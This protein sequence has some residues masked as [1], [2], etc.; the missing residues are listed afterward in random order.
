[1]EAITLGEISK[2]LAW[3]V[4][5]IGSITAIIVALKKIIEKQLS[6]I[7]HKI[8]KLD[9][10]I[11]HKIEKL[12]I[13]Q[14]RN[15]LVEFLADVENGIKKDEAQITRANEV[16]DHYTNDLKRNSYI[17]NKWEKLMK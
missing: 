10:N 8:E 11:N 14:C 13:N 7:N 17:K 1:M 3:I 12:D 5:F 6:P 15:Y 2:T 4:A 16:Y 9:E